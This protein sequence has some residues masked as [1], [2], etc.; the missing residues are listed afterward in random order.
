MLEQAGIDKTVQHHVY[1]K[2]E[3]A[4]LKGVVTFTNGALFGLESTLFENEII[5]R[6]GSG[7][8]VFRME[9]CEHLVYAAGGECSDNT[10]D[11]DREQKDTIEGS[12]LKYCALGSYGIEI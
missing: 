3:K 10:D 7:P 2:P 6:A 9:M 8:M 5:A 12:D 1:V 11:S 4:K